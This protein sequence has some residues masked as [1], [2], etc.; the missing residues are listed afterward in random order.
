MSIPS[1]LVF[2]F[3]FP[4]TNPFGKLSTWNKHTNAIRFIN[5]EGKVHRG[6]VTYK[7][8][9]INVKV[10]GFN[11]KSNNRPECLD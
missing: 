2:G 11:K 10:H 4:L 6:Y 9:G 7:T 1:S 8:T 3:Y 5:D